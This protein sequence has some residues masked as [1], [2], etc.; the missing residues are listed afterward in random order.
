VHLKDSSHQLNRIKMGSIAKGPARFNMTIW[1]ISIGLI[2]LSCKG[3]EI[4]P[5]EIAE[6]SGLNYIDKECS[7]CDFI[8]EEGTFT[9]DA[10]AMGVQP[11]DTIGIPGGQRDQMRF[12]NLEGTK[13]NPIVIINCDGR[14]LLGSDINVGTG[15]E[16]VQSKYFHIAGV[17]DIEST[18]GIAVK[19]YFGLAMQGASTDYNAYGIEVLGAGYLGIGAR[20][21][22]TC[23]G[24]ISR[25]TFT[26]YN[27]IIHDNYIHDT[28]GEGIYVG[29]SHWAEGWDGDAGC[30]G[31]VLWEP[32]LIGVR[33]YNNII[34]N[35]GRDGF[36][37][38]SAVEDCEL[39]NN[40]VTNYGLLNTYGHTTGIQ[41]GPGTTGKVYNNFVSDGP[42]YGIAIFGRGDITAFN[43]LIINPGSGFGT[44]ERHPTPGLGFYIVN[45]TII[46][47]KE[48]GIS[49]FENVTVG[50]V[51]HNNIIVNPVQDFIASYA[52]LIEFDTLNNYFTY[53]IGE[54]MFED[55]TKNN[56]MPM[57]GSPAVD[58][59]TDVSSYSI[60]FDILGALRPVNEYDIGA[61]ERQ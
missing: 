61:Y 30:P 51:Y 33:V 20:S 3:K 13:D 44:F 6:V 60:E 54:L 59:G 52:G 46:N 34:N 5:E 26:Q 7:T 15:I 36:Q 40:L 27:T 55:I 29:G 48:D 45:N 43:N 10:K 41:L 53:D 22:A 50:T 32:E 9:F 11:G 8:V 47:P 2:L 18:Y 57:E 35:T 56:Y 38:G 39:Y 42:G 21:D 37:V 58:G 14:A 12:V 19:G 17:G 28:G 16:I 23:D 31:T 4:A 49:V 1:L 24:T 25:D